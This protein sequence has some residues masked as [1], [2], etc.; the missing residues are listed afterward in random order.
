MGERRPISCIWSGAAAPRVASDPAPGVGSDPAP[1]VGS[2]PA[3]GRRR[4]VNRVI[5]PVLVITTVTFGAFAQ[6]PAAA[7][8]TPAVQ[9]PNPDIHYQLGPDS[10]PRD[11]VP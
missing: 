6:Q 3:E 9:A 1:G 8:T 11:G 4:L 7:P 10:L 5:L 2:D